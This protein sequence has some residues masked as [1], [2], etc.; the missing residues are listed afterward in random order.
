L[1]TF[2]GHSNSVNSAVY[3][4]DGT[5][6]LSASSD[7]TIR[8]WDWK[9]GKCITVFKGHSLAVN[10]AVYSSNGM[11]ILSTSCDNGHPIKEWCIKTGDCLKTYKG[12][13][14]IVKKARYINDDRKILSMS[15]DGTLKEWC[16][17]DGKCLNSS[18]IGWFDPYYP[19]VEELPHGITI[20]PISAYQVVVSEISRNLYQR[21]ENV[22]QLNLLGCSFKNLHPD[23]DLSEESKNLMRQYGAVM[24]E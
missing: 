18:A 7:K 9:T 23:S 19:F 16:V 13:K 2:N 4:A 21:I 22:P 5:R 24:D 10:S 3:S 11:K 6:V 20:K 15:F 17:K 14:R 1:K 8:E 12:H